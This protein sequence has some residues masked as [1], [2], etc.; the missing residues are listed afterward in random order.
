MKLAT[1]S[2]IPYLIILALSTFLFN[3]VM[4]KDQKRILIEQIK[5]S[6]RKS[7]NELAKEAS[8]IHYSATVGIF[9]D[10]L[11]KYLD[12]P[13]TAYAA[14]LSIDRKIN[15]PV[16]NAGYDTGKIRENIYSFK[17]VKGYKLE[18]EIELASGE[19][20]YEI[21][22]PVIVPK[23]YYKELAP[24]QPV[25]V[26][27]EQKT[28]KFAFPEF[29]DQLMYISKYAVTFKQVDID[30]MAKKKVQ[31]P[32]FIVIAAIILIFVHRYEEHLLKP[33]HR[34]ITLT[35]NLTRNKD[36]LNYGV[37]RKDEL[38]VL[39]RSI[40]H[41]HDNFLRSINDLSLTNDYA[42]SLIAT[43][44]IS[45]LFNTILL[46]MLRLKDIERGG[47]MYWNDDR[48]RF[49]IKETKNFNDIHKSIGNDESFIQWFLENRTV[50][51]PEDFI[52][53][54]NYYN[55]K[56]VQRWKQYGIALTIPMF[57]H[58]KVVGIV[59]LGRLNNLKEYAVEDIEF[60]KS[61][62]QV[63]VIA[64]EN[65]NLRQREAQ[66]LIIKKDLHFAKSVQQKLLPDEMP[67]LEGIE[68][69]VKTSPARNIGG[70]YYD[71]IRL[72]EGTYGIGIAD[73]SGKGVSAALVMA[74]TR[75]YLRLIA[76]DN[77][78]CSDMLQKM[79]ALLLEDTDKKMFVTMFYAILDTNNSELIFANAGHA[80][81]YIY[82]ASE[83]KSAHIQAKGF[84]LGM[85]EDFAFE[86]S[87]IN[88]E[89]G[90][91]VVFYTDGIIEAENSEKELFGFSRL[92]ELIDKYGSLGAN[93]FLQR[94]MREFK[95]F[96]GDEDQSDDYTILVVKK[97]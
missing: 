21:S 73:V 48:K 27:S 31:T 6:A 25:L 4:F 74:S 9:T 83:Q 23:V 40:A 28:K 3:Y 52:K 32:I 79:N 89:S 5:E 33:L 30:L 87:E 81:P 80:F 38:G 45:S 36:L 78:D 96:I 14:V 19:T 44:N 51:D 37:K 64:I 56:E 20:L 11:N 69:A 39:A 58:D 65:L 10:I 86:S 16:Y 62:A 8:D 95:A 55:N 61:L 13:N 34:L 1:K 67:Q 90:D 63:A 71:F 29:V 53:H 7:A 97:A 82:K 57:R 17:E 12:R 18:R 35:K 22:L 75:S 91:M 46:E 49:V 59:N 2:I 94:F 50:L 85:M 41:M 88:L 92:E 24:K 43:S 76:R 66:T 93:D 47:L 68:F 60:L 70:D 84:P 72:V 42:Q 77:Y 26:F 54:F 15:L